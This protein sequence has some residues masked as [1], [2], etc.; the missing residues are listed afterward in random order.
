MA[1]PSEG[2]R[3]RLLQAAAELFVESGFRG[4]TIRSVCAAAGVNV[5]M[6]NYHFRSKEHLYAEVLNY[7]RDQ[8]LKEPAR[9]EPRDEA[10]ASAHLRDFIKGFL[11]NLLLPGLTSL[12]TKLIRR[13][14]FERSEVVRI[15]VEKDIIPQQRRLKTIVLAIA[16]Q[17]L[18]EADLQHCM[19]SVTGQ[20]VFYLHNRAMNEMLAPHITYDEAGIDSLADHIHR[21]TFH[22][23]KHYSSELP[24]RK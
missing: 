18:S 16:G 4:T 2:T 23:L 6:V 21:F 10:E 15:F 12:L 22:A 5:S 24:S 17:D 3:G 1:N 11:S 14:L 20:A 13:E 9:A 19:F 8:E 7:A